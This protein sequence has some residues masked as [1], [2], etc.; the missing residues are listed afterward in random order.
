MKTMSFALACKDYFGFKP[1]QTMTEFMGEL[2]QL[3]TQ[4]RADLSREFA[5]VGYEITGQPA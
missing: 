3:T 2:K 4:D 1:N 5:K